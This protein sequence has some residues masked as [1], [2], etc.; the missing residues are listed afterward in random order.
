MKKALVVLLVLVVVV[1]GLPIVMGM[2]AMAPCADC[3]P[4]VL[5]ACS[6]AILAAGVAIVL[7]LLALRLGTRRQA[8]RLL[9]HSFLLERP[10]RLA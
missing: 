8:V 9:L 4:A 6:V 3:G 7:A 1:T 2:S 10:P 5:A